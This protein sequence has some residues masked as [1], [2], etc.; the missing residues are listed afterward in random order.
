[1]KGRTEK[2]SRSKENLFW[3]TGRD[4]PNKTII[5]FY[6]YE[7]ELSFFRKTRIR[8]RL[9]QIKKEKKNVAAARNA[10]IYL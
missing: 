4:L 2:G 10:N 8:T 3:E 1:M 6:L 5:Y 9:R 7:I